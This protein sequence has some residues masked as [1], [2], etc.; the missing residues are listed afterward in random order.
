MKKL[1]P[2]TT[3]LLLAIIASCNKSDVST[4]NSVESK[5]PA[6]KYRGATDINLN[7]LLFD[8][9]KGAE[10]DSTDPQHTHLHLFSRDYLTDGSKALIESN[11]AYAL[12]EIQANEVI[13]PGTPT[14][15]WDE[16]ISW[17]YW[18][19]DGTAMTGYFID[20]YVTDKLLNHK[21]ELK[22]FKTWFENVVVDWM[23]ANNLAPKVKTNKPGEYWKK[24]IGSVE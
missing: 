13:L 10:K 5:P 24:I 3:T 12:T 19:N 9:L 2:L 18:I 1:I 21:P 15:Q 6:A 20:Y 11:L 16:E 7:I 22:A 14:F 8:E 23:N 17:A 4:V